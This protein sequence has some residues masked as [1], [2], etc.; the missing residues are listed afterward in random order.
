[1][2]GKNKLVKLLSVVI[3]FGVLVTACGAP[4]TQ[5]PAATDAPAR[6]RRQA[7]SSFRGELA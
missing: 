7:A 6:H 3:V 1:M 4:A 2:H 5:P